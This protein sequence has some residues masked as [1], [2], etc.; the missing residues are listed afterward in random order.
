MFATLLLAATLSVSDY[1]TMPQLSAPQWSPDG[2]RIAYVLT[3]ANLETS[4]YDSDV[5]IVSADGSDGRRLTFGPGTDSRPRWSPDGKRIAFLSDR[6]GRA[7]VYVMPVDGGEATRLFEAATAVREFEWSPDGTTI[8]FTRIEPESDEWTARVKARDDARVVGAGTQH[9]HLHLADVASGETRQLTRGAYSIAGFDWAPD[10]SR[11][12]IDQAPQTGLDGLYQTDLHVVRTDDGGRVPLVVRPGL[13]RRARWSPDGKWI[14]FTSVGGTS[15]WIVEHDIHVVPAT[16]GSPRRLSGDA[17]SRTPEDLQWSSDAA[18]VS[19]EAP[20]GL[21]TRIVRLGLDGSVTMLTD[22]DILHVDADFHGGRAAYVVQ[23]LNAPPE[24]HVDGR[25][26]TDHNSAYRT[27]DLGETRVIRWKNPKDGREIEGLLTL[28]P[29]FRTGSRLPLLTF[30]HGGPASRFDFG[31]LGY[32]GTLYAPHALAAE[33]FAVLRPNPRGTGGYGIDFR[34]ANRSD[35]AGMD[36][37]DVEAGIDEV[38]ADGIA[39]PDRLGLMGWSYGGYLASWALAHSDRFR[40]ISIGAPVVDLLSF[41][42]TTDIRG[43]IPSYFPAMPRELLRARSPLWH[44]RKTDTKVLI[45]HGESDDRVPL[46]QGSMLYRVLDDL[47]VDVTM[48]IYP[49]TPHTPQEPKLRID[50][51]RR[52]LEFFREHV[53]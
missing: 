5:W 26:I 34:A 14:A 53:K 2:K 38:I 28:P 33:G 11:I 10:G 32:L 37:L 9:V 4:K 46:S 29:D 6:G 50:V 48:V 42:G 41:H 13:D 15:H 40:A 30:I 47:G 51:A 12:V 7:S 21:A 52:N 18:S 45:Q 43:F 35:W 17:I 23:S 8:A 31:Y 19:V 49:R 16:G 24:L 25:R 44:L 36:W 20:F 1:A 27:R 3:Q 22:G 39:D